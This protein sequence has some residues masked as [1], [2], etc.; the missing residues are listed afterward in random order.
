VPGRRRGAPPRA[1]RVPGWL[2]RSTSGGSAAP[3]LNA[4]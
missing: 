4:R 3:A 1:S 2:R